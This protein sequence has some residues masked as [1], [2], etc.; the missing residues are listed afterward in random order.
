MSAKQES[1][2][3]K[4]LKPQSGEDEPTPYKERVTTDCNE[5]TVAELKS[6]LTELGYKEKFTYMRKPALVEAV[7]KIKMEAFP[8]KPSAQ[9][10]DTASPMLQD[11]SVSMN[12]KKRKHHERDD[13]EESNRRLEQLAKEAKVTVKRHLPAFIQSREQEASTKRQMP[14]FLRSPQITNQASS[15]QSKLKEKPASAAKDEQLLFSDTPEK[16][17]SASKSQ[18]KNQ[19]SPLGFNNERQQMIE[20]SQN[21]AGRRKTWGQPDENSV[22]EHRPAAGSIKMVAVGQGS[23]INQRNS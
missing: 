14:A 18:S 20:L 4:R 23:N 7:V 19:Q 22:I 5:K 8:K 11:Q 6:T 9:K 10:K 15:G 21:R 16:K 13:A 17:V 3:L 12:S 2:F 1:A